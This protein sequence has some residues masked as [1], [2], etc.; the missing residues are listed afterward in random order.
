MESNKTETVNK[1]RSP[2]LNEHTL[3]HTKRLTF[4]VLFMLFFRHNLC[5]DCVHEEALRVVTGE[6]V[7]KV[8]IIKN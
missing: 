3:R 4:F 2:H 7:A 8:K 5:E 1:A 6:N